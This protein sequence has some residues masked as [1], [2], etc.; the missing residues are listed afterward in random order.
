MPIAKPVP[1][2]AHATELRSA[3]PAVTSG[4]KTSGTSQEPDV[5]NKSDKEKK[6]SNA[7]K[8]TAIAAKA[9]PRCRGGTR[10][11]SKGRGGKSRSRRAKTRTA[12]ERD[13]LIA[14][15]MGPLWGIAW[16][17]AGPDSDLAEELRAHVLWK[18]ALGRYNPRKGLFTA[19]VRRVMTRQLITLRQ[20]R[21]RAAGGEENHPERV[22]THTDTSADDM[23]T[24]P[25]PAG[26]LARIM[27]WSAQ[28]II[29][30]LSR[31]LLWRKLPVEMWAAALAEVGL[32][33]SFPGP[34]FE[35]TSIA[36]QNLFLASVCGGPRNTVH[37][38][39]KRWRRQLLDLQF[40]REHLPLDFDR[41][42]VER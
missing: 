26:D 14:L 10:K 29:V 11:S 1:R 3:Q 18:C 40:V 30:L 23:F 39:M 9:F 25:F 28:Q 7:M 6:L 32:P 12:E 15:L 21:G 17:L 22:D 41:D 31:S 33:A 24:A 13:A 34:L 4:L 27:K 5:E 42:D 36:E 19:W 37:V 8:L 2:D 16:R 35:V 38:Q 20:S